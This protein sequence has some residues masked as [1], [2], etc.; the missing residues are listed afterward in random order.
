MVVL[1]QDLEVDHTLHELP[2]IVNEECYNSRVAMSH[3][4]SRPGVVG[5]GD[6]SF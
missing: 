6:S 4:A 2:I 3:L 5:I 1:V